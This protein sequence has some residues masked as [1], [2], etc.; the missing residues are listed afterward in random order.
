MEIVCGA[1][2]GNLEPIEGVEKPALGYLNLTPLFPIP[3]NT[4]VRNCVV[5]PAIVTELAYY[6]VSLVSGNTPIAY[7][8]NGIIVALAEGLCATGLSTEVLS[9]TVGDDRPHRIAMWAPTQLTSAIY[10]NTVFEKY[11]CI[12]AT[13]KP[14][15]RFSLV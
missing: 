12:A 5:K 2:I 9:L 7:L 11:L 13:S 4:E 15:H 10:A 6:R 14:L 1:A 3:I 8:L